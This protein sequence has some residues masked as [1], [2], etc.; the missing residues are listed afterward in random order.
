MPLDLRVR[1]GYSSGG[2]NGQFEVSVP[3]SISKILPVTQPAAGARA[4]GQA[5]LQGCDQAIPTGAQDPQPGI[6]A[7]EVGGD[8]TGAVRGAIVHQHALPVS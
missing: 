3:P 7:G 2:S 8:S 1:H 6:V 4:L 5:M